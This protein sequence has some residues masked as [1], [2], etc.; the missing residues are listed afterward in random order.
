MLDSGP[1]RKSGERCK[2]RWMD[3]PS[4]RRA[5]ERVGK[6]EG[7]GGI[8]TDA[9]KGTGDKIKRAGSTGKEPTRAYR[10]RGKFILYRQP[11][12]GKSSLA[13]P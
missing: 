4:M 7:E 9:G 11:E 8:V 6:G 1:E 12:M 3:S 10:G 13:L 2:D 5:D